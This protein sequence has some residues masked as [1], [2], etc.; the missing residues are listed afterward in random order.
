MWRRVSGIELELI[1]KR[2]LWCVC[3]RASVGTRTS[4]CGSRRCSRI[5]FCTS[6][7]GRWIL[8]LSIIFISGTKI[9]TCPI[10][11]VAVTG[12]SKSFRRTELIYKHKRKQNSPDL[13][14]NSNDCDVVC[15]F[16]TQGLA[17]LSVKRGSEKLSGTRV[18]GL[19]GGIKLELDWRS[20]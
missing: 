16:I 12:G 19:T 4:V 8:T 20:L 3:A 15:S 10:Y 2:P 1:G 6:L 5:L 14:T 13:S 18:L 11:C 17:A 9:F 7:T